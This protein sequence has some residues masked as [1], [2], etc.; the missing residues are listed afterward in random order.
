MAFRASG[1]AVDAGDLAQTFLQKSIA[2]AM[3]TTALGIF[4][5]IPTLFVHAILQS[6]INA[7]ISDI[8]QYS[9]KLI[10]TARCSSPVADWRRRASPR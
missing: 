4:V 1:D 3:H 2:I 5:A 8:E 6:K 10:G 7:I 9:V